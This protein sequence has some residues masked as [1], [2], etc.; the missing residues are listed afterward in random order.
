MFLYLYIC[1][2]FFGIPK[3]CK[4][5]KNICLIMNIKPQGETELSFRLKPSLTQSHTKPR[6]KTVREEIILAKEG[7]SLKDNSVS[8]CNKT[9][10][11]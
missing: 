5:P 7:I 3:K 8:Y 10:N 9:T 2:L 11:K 1:E 4:I 6:T